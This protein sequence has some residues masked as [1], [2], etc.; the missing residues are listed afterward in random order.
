MKALALGLQNN[1][2][3]SYD[4]TKT[5][6][7]GRIGQKSITDGSITKN[8]IGPNPVLS[9]D[10]FDDTGVAPVGLHTST[11]NGRIFIG[12]GVVSNVWTVSYYLLTTV[13]GNVSAVWQGDLK[14]TFG[15]AALTYVIKGFTVDDS[16]PASM[17]FFWNATHTT[18]TDGGLF[19]CWGINVTDF[20][21]VSIVTFPVA[22][23]GSQTKTVYQLG[24][25]ASQA[26]QT[27]TV[28]EGVGYDGVG[29]FCYVLNGA[30]ATPSVFKFNVASPPSASP[31]ANGY[32]STAFVLKTGTLAALS[33]VIL[34]VNNLQCITPSH[35]SNSGSLCLSL[36]TS[37]NIYVAKVSDITSAVTTLPSLVTANVAISTDY[38]APATI[39]IGQYIAAIDK[40]ILLG[41]SGDF[42]IKQCVSND[43]NGV[44]FGGSNQI[45]TEIGGTINTFD[46]GGITN[47]CLSDCNG[48][49]VITETAIG[50]R[51]ALV[52]DLQ[53][54][55]QQ[56]NPST[57]QIQASIISPVINGNFSKGIYL[58]IY[59]ELSKRTVYPTIQ[60]RTS[61]FS[62]GPGAGFDALWT[63]APIDGDLSLLSNAT[64][65]QF[66]ILFRSTNI[67]VS[68]ASQIV[69]SYLLY[70]DLT[71]SSENWV[72]SSSNTSA[73]GS[74][75]FRVSFRLQTAYAT[76]VPKLFIRGIDDSGNAVVFDTVTNIANMDYTTNNGTSYT[77]LGTIPNTPLTTELRF[78]W[79]SPDGVPRRWAVSES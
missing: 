19:G 72:G 63:T 50:Q 73:S 5:T 20:V 14:F 38:V 60:Y 18:T 4:Q 10:I 37:T 74:N 66:R 12:K 65:V 24:D 22:S 69:E 77:P 32:D 53:V 78:S 2:V 6:L 11:P 23:A 17:K 28:A 70:I 9:L 16:N 3:T 7:Q 75:P 41:V 42:F 58:S 25:N 76:S 48:F 59:K 51:G 47:L 44:V 54:D 1:I 40:W 52:I 8:C 64:Q 27:L 68:N 45:K 30:A 15:A 67:D 39:T 56:V 34:L 35:T 57:G 43:A 79:T 13:A 71:Q 29:G 61:G 26:S 49:A 31:A 33:G 21:K 55:Y 46:F 62:T 36:L